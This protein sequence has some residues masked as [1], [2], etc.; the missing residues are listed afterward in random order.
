MAKWLR[1]WYN[2]F[3]IKIISGKHHGRKL[4]TPVGR[5]V[6]PTNIRARTALFNIICPWLE[7]KRVLEL[8]A[9]SGSIGFECL[10]RGASHITFVENSHVSVKCLTENAIALREEENTTIIRHDIRRKL[11]F[12]SSEEN[13]FDFIFA[14]PPYNYF[15]AN[16][17]LNVISKANLYNKDSIIIIEH[18][19]KNKIDCD[20][21]PEGWDC[22][23]NSQ[24]G[25]AMLSFF[26]N[27]IT[28]I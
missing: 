25:K 6:R 16:F 1:F 27:S 22:Y 14:D 9:G 2:S 17:I 7:G 8:F 5:D 18:D 26:S 13:C 21:L 24:Y 19:A 10:S 4:F 15:S 11:N 28:M 3:M 12:L 20:E 23:R